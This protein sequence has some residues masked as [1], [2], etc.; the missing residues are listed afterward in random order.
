MIFG[1]TTRATLRFALVIF[2]KSQQLV[3][4]SRNI[5]GNVHVTRYITTDN[6]LKYVDKMQFTSW[7]F[8]I[9]S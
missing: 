3:K 5:I 6:T 1:N 4:F 9:H 2:P 7:F 8:G